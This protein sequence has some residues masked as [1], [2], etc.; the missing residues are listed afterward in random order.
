[1]RP[2]EEVIKTANEDIMETGTTWVLHVDR[3]RELEEWEAKLGWTAGEMRLQG[4]EPSQELTDSL[5]TV[6]RL[7]GRE[8]PAVARHTETIVIGGYD[9]APSQVISAGPTPE[10]QWDWQK[11]LKPKRTARQVAMELI[12]GLEDGSITLYPD[13]DVEI[14]RLL[15]REEPNTNSA[16]VSTKLVNGP[17]PAFQAMREAIRML[18]Q[19]EKRCAKAHVWSAA[20]RLAREAQSLADAELAAEQPAAGKGEGE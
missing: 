16:P 18:L 12:E 2:L 5:A 17:S 9:N 13:E 3:R 1:M 20:F 6:R 10:T 11:T 15:G 8:E 14:R 19:C 7:L 4:H